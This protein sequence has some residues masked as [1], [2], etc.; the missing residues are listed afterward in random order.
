MITV[1]KDKGHTIVVI[2]GALTAA[3]LQSFSV[4]LAD[5]VRQVIFD[6]SAL[7]DFDTAGAWKIDEEMRSLRARGIAADI[8]GLHDRHR[9]IFDRV[10]TLPHDADGLRASAPATL[11]AG[12]SALGETLLEVWQDVLRGVS[13]FGHIAAALP[14]SFFGRGKIRWR[15]V[16]FHI[17]EVGIKA[18][19]IIALMAF[20][21]A[22]VT[23]YQGAF[24]LQKFDATIYT[25]DLI[26]LSTLREMGVLITAIMVAGRS[27]SAFAAQ[28]GTMKLNEEVDALQTM[29]VSPFEALVL[30]RILA[31]VIALPVLTVVANFMGLLG[32][33]IFS[34]SSLGYSHVQFLSRM[35]E[36]ADMKHFYV[37]LSKA[38]VFAVL[39]GIVG[40]MQGLRARGSAEDVGRKT[41]TA[42][43]QSIFLV[44]V[45]DAIFSVIFT[46]V[47]I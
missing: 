20:S 15:S 35:Q 42:V 37:G 34:S 45:A 22:F 39:I 44:I 38:P 9:K 5:D 16:I 28:I 36:A 43:V 26:V 25:V 10:S 1:R 7:T 41:I 40:C 6:V 11:R 33:Y 47:G 4:I 32:G 31:I 18:C 24:Q 12:V 17:N 2:E 46:K 13:F 19:P 21:I 23:G 14:P 3:T 29:G 8:S 27:G 30:P